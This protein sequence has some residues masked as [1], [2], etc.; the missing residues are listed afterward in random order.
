MIISRNETGSY[1][2]NGISFL[3][4]TRKYSGKKFINKNG[5]QVFKY[6]IFWN[7]LTENQ[8]K[9]KYVI[10]DSDK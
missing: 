9:M 3:E 10:T 1:T 2:V 7:G 8:I 6:Q 4:F 5:M